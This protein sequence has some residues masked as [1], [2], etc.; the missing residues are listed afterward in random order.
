[1]S[2]HN[3][4]PPLHAARVHTRAPWAVLLE[5][6]LLWC[7]ACGSSRLLPGQPADQQVRVELTKWGV[8]HT[9]CARLPVVERTP[10]LVPPLPTSTASTAPSNRPATDDRLAGVLAELGLDPDHGD[11]VAAIRGLRP[12]LREPVAHLPDADADRLV[13]AWGRA[14]ELAEKVSNETNRVEMLAK[15][16]S[17]ME[18]GCFTHEALRE[19]LPGLHPDPA[20]IID[21]MRGGYE[22][23][24]KLVGYRIL[25]DWHAGLTRKNRDLVFGRASVVSPKARGAWRGGGVR[26]WWRVEL[27]LPYWLAAASDAARW[28][29]VHHE[30]MHLAVLVTDDDEGALDKPGLRN[31]D[32]EEFVA[33][34]RRFGPSGEAQELLIREGARYLARSGAL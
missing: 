33:T 9:R 19:V 20:D 13:D 22:E 25:V 24:G 23:F 16:L 6:R 10:P 26:P 18:H 34:V 17:R 21:E 14:A 1:M 32:V 30:L 2:D 29:L 11:P 27:S 5:G 3:A 12:A 8:E 28:R 7:R 4:L 15:D 31:H